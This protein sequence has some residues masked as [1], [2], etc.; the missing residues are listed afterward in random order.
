MSEAPS[1]NLSQQP[2]TLTVHT[3]RHRVRMLFTALILVMFLTILRAVDLPIGGWIPIAT[4]AVLATLFYLEWS[5]R[6]L[7][8]RPDD[9][10]DAVTRRLDALTQVLPG[11]SFHLPV[12]EPTGHHFVSQGAEDIYEIGRHEFHCL[13]DLS[14]SISAVDRGTAQALR[15]E[16]LKHGE[17]WELVYRVTAAKDETRWVWECGQPYRGADDIDYAVGILLDVTAWHRME[18]RFETLL[19]ALDHIAHELYVVD[20][21]TLEFLYVNRATLENLQYSE[22]EIRD[23]TPVD[24]GRYSEEELARELQPLVTGEVPEMRLEDRLTRRD[25]ST[26][27]IALTISMVPFDRREAFLAIGADITEELA[28]QERLRRSEERYELAVMASNDGVW[29]W[30]AKTNRFNMSLRGKHPPWYETEG[31][32][33]TFESFIARIHPDDQSKMVNALDA[34]REN[35]DEFSVEFRFRTQGDQYRWIHTSGQAV[36]DENGQPLRMAG[37]FSDVTSRRESDALLQDTVSR[38]G[39]VLWN[40]ADG[41]IT[42]DAEGKIRSFNPAAERIFECNEHAIVGLAISELIPIPEGD[43]ETQDW[44]T[45]WGT[46]NEGRRHGGARFHLELAISTMTVSGERMYTAVLRDISQRKKVEQALVEAKDRAEAA[47]RSKTEFLA[48]MSHEIRTPMNGVLGMTQLLLDM[49]LDPE[50]RDI[51]AMIYSSGESLLSIINDVLD[52]SKIEA[53]KLTLEAIPFD[54]RATIGDVT[55]LMSSKALQKG[56]ELLV[57]YPSDV[58]YRLIGDVGR[59]RQ[60]LVNLVG[61]AVKF[62]DQGHVVTRVALKNLERDHARL[63]VVVEDT[64]MGI[65]PAEQERLFEAFTQADA[66][67]TRRFGGTGLGLAICRQLTSLMGGEIGVDSEHGEGSRFWFTIELPLDQSKTVEETPDQLR[68][69]HALVVDDNPM[70]RRIFHHML[71]EL[72]MTVVSVEGGEE[73]LEA[74]ADGLAQDR[75]FDVAL[76]DYHMPGMDG[77]ALVSKIRELETLADLRLI[78]LTSSGQ[79][80]ERERLLDLGI[81][82]Y[83]LKP[84]LFQGLTREL[85]RVYGSPR[86]NTTRMAQRTA[87]PPLDGLRVLLAED[88]VVNQKVAVKMLETLGCSV[89]VANNGTEALEMWSKYCY[90]LVF[91]DVHMPGMDGIEATQ[92]MRETESNTG[93]SRT[94]IIAMTANAME[95]DAERCF[96]AGMDDYAAKP[97]KKEILRSILTKWKERIGDDQ[98]G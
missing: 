58:P 83:L 94:P 28:Q 63:Q 3:I 39:A 67:T 5:M 25:G 72:E 98:A 30:D 96:A 1:E 48:T 73:A 75:R 22:Q 12:R 9:S 89:D 71:R 34:Y 64:G 10:F 91:M 56:V 29:D 19:T 24:L 80:G 20:T 6:G 93:R 68:G 35:R 7:A 37:C 53:G 46:E 47:A 74:L 85:L 23:L 84:V 86:T 18:Q 51:A 42:F 4:A 11:A 60:V 43:G 45:V 82:G 8:A 15:D 78:M 66:S 70:G 79:S 97:V 69:L 76:L 17:A 92:R 65:E 31:E 95:G 49:N 26:Y 13:A 16:A 14:K 54:L 27:P 81:D 38:L 57:D 52:F 88:N 44:I 59:I 40:V 21:E 32:E 41:I 50:Q 90:K 87:V 55:G 62:T 77:E 61:N 33:A 36:W 2:K